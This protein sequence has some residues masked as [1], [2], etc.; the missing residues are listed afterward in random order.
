MSLNGK[1]CWTKLSISS[2]QGTQQCGEQ[3]NF[4]PWNEDAIPVTGCSITLSGSGFKPL[5]V[6]VWTSLDARDAKDESF[7]IANVV[8]HNVKSSTFCCPN[9]ASCI[10]FLILGMH[11]FVL[12]YTWH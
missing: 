1:R 6:R 4:G 10:G 8:I 2:S 5:T 11:A 3:G 12:Q 9:R 7:G